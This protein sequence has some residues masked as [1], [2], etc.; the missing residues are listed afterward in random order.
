MR[1]ALV[2]SIVALGMTFSAPAFAGGSHHGSGGAKIGAGL[3]L[4]IG[5]K[6]LAKV[7]VKVGLRLGVGIGL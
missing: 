2:A 4:G 1:K 6:G 5:V 7:K 3:K